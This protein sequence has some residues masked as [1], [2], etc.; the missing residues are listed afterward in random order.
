MEIV[1]HPPKVPNYFKTETTY[2]YWAAAITNHYL[3]MITLANIFI[4]QHYQVVKQHSFLLAPQPGQMIRFYHFLD[5][6]LTVVPM[7]IELIVL[8]ILVRS[9]D[10]DFLAF[11]SVQRAI[12]FSVFHNQILHHQL[13]TTF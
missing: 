6:L 7:M 13:R 4:H 11:S 1:F 8:S 12:S 3:K 5:L 2:Y 10:A 9:V